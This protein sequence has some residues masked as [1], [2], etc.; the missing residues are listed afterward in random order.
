MPFDRWLDLIPLRLRALFRGA[1]VDREL[2]EEL[3]YHVDR[4]TELNIAQGMTPDAART[5]ALR[6][7]G[8]LESRKEELREQ[9]ATLVVEHVL[10]DVRYAVRVLRRS[11]IFAVA[12]V[13]V[14]ALGIG[15]N[16]AMFA[17]ID[18]VVLRRLPVARPDQI[19][20]I[21]VDG[22]RHDFGIGDGFNAEMTNPLWE[23]I[24]THQHG[25]SGMFAWAN[26]GL[27]AGDGADRQSANG[28]W[29]SGDY[30]P[31]LGVVPVRGRLLDASDDRPG[32]GAGPVVVSHAFWQRY[33]GGRDS[34]VGAT[35][36]ILDRR[37]T[38]VG[39]A[40]AA[41]TGLEVGRTFDVALP[42]CSF[43]LLGDGLERR[44]YFWLTVMGRLRPQWTIAQS[45]EQM[46]TISPGLFEAT[47]PSGYSSENTA[48]Y[49]AF[50]L[51]VLPA[52]R[53]V[54]QLRANFAPALWL[55]LGLTALVLLITSANLATLML[56]RAVG[57][58]REF[59]VRVALGASRWRILSQAF[60]ESLIVAALGA[61]CALPVA[62]LSSRAMVGL[63]STARN[64][65][66]LTVHLDWRV[67]VFTSAVAALAAIV[68]GLVPAIRASRVHPAM[69]VSS[70]RGLT[71]DRHRSIAQ[72]VLLVSQVA[73]SLVLAV[74]ASFFVRSFQNLIGAD[75][76]FTQDRV[77]AVNVVDLQAAELPLEQRLAFQATLTDEIR[78]IPGVVAASSSTHTPLS[79]ATWWHGFIASIP[80]ADRTG[81]PWA[82]VDPGYFNTLQ[83]PLV[84]GRGITPFDTASSKRV[85]VVNESFVREHLHGVPPIGT[86]LRTYAEPGY[87]ELSYEIVGVVRDTTYAD[88]RE[89]KRSIAFSPLAQDP[90]LRPWAPVLVRTSGPPSM[91]T[92]AI[93]E[94]VT[95]LNRGVFIGF[96]ELR[97]QLAERLVGER[98]LAWLSGGFGVLAM[99]L[100][101]FGL[102]GIVAYLAGGRRNEIGIRLSLGS[103]RLQIIRLVMGDSMRLVIL[104]LMIGL[105][106]AI[107]LMRTASAL[108]FG[109]SATDV[110][111]LAAAVVFLA[112]AAGI[113][114]LVPAWRASRLDP[115]SALR[116]E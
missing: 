9:R 72:R 73:V 107:A 112:M 61:I 109:L 6:A 56:A 76:G 91:V 78:A 5:A 14:L 113:A 22:Y 34:A 115:S 64:P 44:E 21:R 71:G 2:D 81:T 86:T 39:V 19:A 23:L 57:R 106:I 7:I 43:A 4:Q 3:R 16:A 52:E 111:P 13:G 25:F 83:I 70:T 94:R 35:L 28:L 41:F 67:A 10:R 33:F 51:T 102:Y 74:A 20:E 37:F 63:L 18:T 31:V 90:A 27:L 104:G 96:T 30:F 79:G 85:V 49:R 89:G 8:G 84:A 29:V 53:G 54:S 32:C 58:E 24:R 77:M 82:Y 97:V 103:S 92:Q 114:A 59:T 40:P 101:S 66:A 45:A 98:M 17:L 68:F 12:A 1:D 69:A 80:G 99:M 75:T 42:I 110:G 15:A 108:L 26:M 50:R 87:P 100:A 11:P 38:V 105:P 62:V 47:V 93:K 46:R 48:R 60:I 55:L 116:A 36:T 88:L 65:V 95:R